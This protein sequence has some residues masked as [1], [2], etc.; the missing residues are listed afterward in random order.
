MEG[1][2]RPLRGRRDEESYDPPR[3]A[4]SPEKKKMGEEG[5]STGNCIKDGKEGLFM[6]SIG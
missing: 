1:K 6:K 2:I 4:R 3:A 5:L